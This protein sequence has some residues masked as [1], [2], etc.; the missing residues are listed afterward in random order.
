MKAI[1]RPVKD[2]NILEVTVSYGNGI[3][4]RVRKPHVTIEN[5]QLKLNEIFMSGQS[6]VDV[7]WEKEKEKIEKRNVSGVFYIEVKHDG[8]WLVKT[9]MANVQ[10][11]LI[12][13][14][15]DQLSTAIMRGLDQM[16]QGKPPDGKID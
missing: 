10:Q 6:T 1:I 3:V 13:K 15:H 11:K 12:P 4:Y 16:A 8:L 7:L 9:S 14:M 5:L 2:R